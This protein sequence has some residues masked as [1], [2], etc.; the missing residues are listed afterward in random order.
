MATAAT[1][2]V[3]DVDGNDQS[4]RLI[5]AKRPGAAPLVLAALEVGVGE[6]SVA[7]KAARASARHLEAFLQA[8]H[9][10]RTNRLLSDDERGEL[11]RAHASKALKDI[12]AEAAK[13]SE[14]QSNLRTRTALA[15]IGDPN[16]GQQLTRLH[17]ADRLDR[18]PETKRMQLVALAAADPMNHPLTAATIT[19]LPR[20]MTGITA[21][22]QTDI[23]VAAFAARNP[24]EHAAMTAEHGL[25]ATA[26][27]ALSAAIRSVA[28]EVGDH[29]V[30]SE[31]AP[32]AER[33]IA[34][35]PAS[36]DVA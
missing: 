4:G 20:E 17:W 29:R 22:E 13:V 15:G 25:A 31:H 14:W 10:V 3:V 11:V 35:K 32:T 27:V 12:D 5:Q 8:S 23:R 26:R 19:L 16:D 9:G 24:E 34:T 21:K 6:N 7:V 30:I 36:W 28:A 33:L 2:K 18:M 1:L